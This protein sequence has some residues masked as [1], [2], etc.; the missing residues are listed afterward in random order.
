VLDWMSSV[1]P[2]KLVASTWAEPR[3]A[4]TAACG[5]RPAFTAGGSDLAMTAV[6]P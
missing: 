2:E 6:A 3:W 4:V 1:A 5:L